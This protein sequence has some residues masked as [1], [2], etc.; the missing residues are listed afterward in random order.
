MIYAQ[1][2]GGSNQRAGCKSTLSPPEGVGYRLFTGSW[3]VAGSFFLFPGDLE[4]T[5]T[6]VVIPTAGHSAIL[7]FSVDHVM[8]VVTSAAFCIGLHVYSAGLRVERAFLQ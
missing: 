2:A 3:P 7:D 8:N 6:V 5:L 1:Y 4:I